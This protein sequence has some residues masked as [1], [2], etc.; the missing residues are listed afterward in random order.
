MSAFP[1]PQVLAQ[2]ASKA[3]THYKKRENDAQ[4]EKRLDL[5]DGWKLL[6]TASNDNTT[7]GYFGSAY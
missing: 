3:H 4:Y 6:M 7:N 1:T 2:F 5:P